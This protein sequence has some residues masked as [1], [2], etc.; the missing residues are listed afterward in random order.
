MKTNLFKILAVFF[1]LGVFAIASCDKPDP[2]QQSAEDDAR[3]GYMMADAFAL[4][5][6]NA[7]DT[8]GGKAYFPE[9]MVVE[10]NVLTHTVTITFTNCDYKGAVRNG[11]VKIKHSLA[12]G[13]NS[14]RAFNLTV[15]FENYTMDGVALEGT[16][17]TTFG[18]TYSQPEIHV[19]ATGMKATF[20]DD[21]VLTWSSDKTFTIEEGFAKPTVPN[22]VVMSGTASGVNRA[23]VAFNSTYTNVKLNRA[24]EDSKYPVS[25]TV[26]IES[27]K[28]TTV[29]D[30]G[31]GECDNI[32]SIT[33]NGVTI[34]ITLE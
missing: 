31:N 17:N 13:V 29:I 19:V 10:R 20:T 6:D 28:G 8:G 34:E 15:T 16:I 5:N 11:V 21:K 27:D 18:G 25:G 24:C 30:Y 33:N 9:G 32:V 2:D 12:I 1:A 26:T 4:G 23:G 22:V 3:G 7:G 14:P